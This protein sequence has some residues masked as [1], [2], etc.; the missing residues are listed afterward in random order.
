MQ[1]IF[2]DR[3]RYWKTIAD[4]VPTAN[5]V[6]AAVAYLG[7]GGA[8]FL[9]LRSG[10][11]LLVD[12]SYGAVRQGATDPREIKKLINRGVE[13]FTRRTLHAKLVVIDNVVIV[14]SANVSQNARSH[15]DEAAILST[16]SAVARSAREF[17]RSMCSEPVR[18]HYLNECLKL[19]KP[20]IFKASRTIRQS[21]KRKQR[22]KLWYIGGLTYMDDAE[23]QEFFR[24]VESEIKQEMD[25]PVDSYL[26]K[27]RLS[28]RKNWFTNIQPNNWVIMCCKASKRTSD[29]WGPAR[30]IRKWK[31]TKKTGRTYH[32]LSLERP[33]D[34]KPM[35]LTS[36][37]QRWRKAARGKQPPLRSQPIRDQSLADAVMRFWTRRGRVSTRS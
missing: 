29:V 4:R 30:V 7:R 35:T 28:H 33:N 6:V 23:D 22:A 24:P 27:I 34:A 8:D 11:V 2:L 17:I 37:R 10:D 14:S 13:V 12:L 32:V 20:P 9:P 26:D 31:Y 25:D 1:A 19:Y 15:L 18:E 16:S 21:V 3:E 36:F 5:K